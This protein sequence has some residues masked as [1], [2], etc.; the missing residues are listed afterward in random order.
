MPTQ[1]KKHE[2]GECPN[3]VFA[4]SITLR[5]GRILQATECGRNVFAFCGCGGRK[6]R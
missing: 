1:T 4:R 6:R 5:N 3:P 2:L